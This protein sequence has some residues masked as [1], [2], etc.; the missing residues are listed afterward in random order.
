MF[1]G[2]TNLGGGHGNA[3]FKNKQNANLAA[4]QSNNDEVYGM[5]SKKILNFEL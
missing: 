2:I 1:R 5:F 4:A 3:L